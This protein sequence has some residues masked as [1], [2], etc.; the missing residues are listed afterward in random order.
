MIFS[1]EAAFSVRWIGRAG[2]AVLK[3]H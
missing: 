3:F 1:S 2:S